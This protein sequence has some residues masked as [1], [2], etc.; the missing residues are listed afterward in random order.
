[1]GHFQDFSEFP[2]R[3]NPPEPSC[4]CR[5]RYDEHDGRGLPLPPLHR[6]LA[7]LLTVSMSLRFSTSCLLSLI[8][9]DATHVLIWSRR[10]WGGPEEERGRGGGG[11]GEGGGGKGEKRSGGGRERDTDTLV[12]SRR[13]LFFSR[14]QT[15]S[16]FWIFFSPRG[17]RKRAHAAS[18]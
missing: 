13:D 8:S 7:P 9:L 2:N 6:S 14:L 15:P 12:E 11:G 17:N 1:M 10:R 18:G 3:R 5:E 16:W 4:S